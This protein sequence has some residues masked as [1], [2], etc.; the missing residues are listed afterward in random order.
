MSQ[1]LFSS[2]RT[3]R[4]QMSKNWVYKRQILSLS[5]MK[6]FV[7]L[8]FM[9]LDA[10]WI[11]QILITA[12]NCQVQDKKLFIKTDLGF[13][14]FFSTDQLCQMNWNSFFIK[15]KNLIKNAHFSGGSIFSVRIC[16]FM[17]EFVKLWCWKC[18]TMTR[19]YWPK[20][21]DLSGMWLSD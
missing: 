3:K 21:I 6:K 12:N 17:L 14:P 18:S 19:F 7:S 2:A 16:D 13:Q 10:A 4:Q 8:D 5:R 9:T 15:K 20:L 1:K 11:H